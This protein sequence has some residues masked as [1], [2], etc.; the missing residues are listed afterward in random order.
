MESLKRIEIRNIGGHSQSYEVCEGRNRGKHK[1][2]G[3]CIC[4]VNQWLSEMKCY[5][6]STRCV[7][8][9]NIGHVSRLCSLDTL[10]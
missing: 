9:G 7:K 2:Y 6:R 3:R 4:F 10:L 8:C 1:R 5:Y